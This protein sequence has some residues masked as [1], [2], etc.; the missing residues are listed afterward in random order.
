MTEL[1]GVPDMRFKEWICDKY[2][3]KY[4]DIKFHPVEEDK[5]QSDFVPCDE[6]FQITNEFIEKYVDGQNSDLS[7][8]D[9]MAG[10]EELRKE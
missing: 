7:K 2:G 9:I 5:D 6:V 1:D 3:I 8:K 4:L 10:L